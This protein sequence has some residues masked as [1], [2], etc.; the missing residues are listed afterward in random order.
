MLP[1]SSRHSSFLMP[2]SGSGSFVSCLRIEFGKLFEASRFS[3]DVALDSARGLSGRTVL[4][5][6]SSGLC[7]LQKPVELLVLFL[8]LDWS[9]FRP[10]HFYT[11]HQYV[12]APKSTVVRHCIL[13]FAG[14][15]FDIMRS[16]RGLAETDS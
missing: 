11:F 15:P 13:T 1:K 9:V 8:H 12:N 7:V 6:F 14:F 4:A 5:R 3:V 2:S 16:R 10:L